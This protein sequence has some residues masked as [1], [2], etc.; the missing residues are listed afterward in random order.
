MSQSRSRSRSSSHRRSEDKD[1]KSSRHDDH[2]RKH[3]N[4][5]SKHDDD[6]EDERL[7]KQAKEFIE[8]HKKGQQD[9]NHRSSK[10]KSSR[11]S[12]SRSP[13]ERSRKRHR[14]DRHDKEEED[15]EGD[16][17]KSSSKNRD[18]RKSSSRKSHKR[19]HDD[20]DHDDGDSKSNHDK[21]KR[22][23][24]SSSRDDKDSRKESRRRAS[25]SSDSDEDRKKRSSKSRDDR[26][27]R[28]H[29]HHKKE[30]KHSSSKKD[31]KKH[32]KK[33]DRKSDD[34]KHDNKS[35]PKKATAKTQKPDKASLVP[36]GDPPGKAPSHLLDADRDYF[37][38]H[39]SLW[40]WLYREEGMAF[41]DMTSDE[42][43]DA[44]GRFV[45]QYN[46]GR[47]EAA[48]YDEKGLPPAAVEECK[49]TRHQ[50]SFQT[51][52][53]ERK[54]L[55]LLEDGVRKLTEYSDA[56][57]NNTSKKEGQSSSGAA[58]GVARK[59]APSVAPRPNPKD[60]DDN[61]GRRQPWTAEERMAHR[62]ANKR[63]KQH[64]RTAE[65]EFGGGAKDYGRERQLEKK[66]EVGARTHGAARDREDPGVT[67][68]DDALYGDGGHGAT[69]QAAL[70]RE[71]KRKAHR[72]ES[73]QARI[74]ELQ[75]KEQS[76]QQAMLDMLGLAGRPAGQKIKIAP[77][78]DGDGT[79]R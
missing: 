16:R 36:L 23:H 56:T 27:D 7:L 51:S 58:L 15:D 71:R 40:V 37:A 18:D 74:Q 35:H 3:R 43:R 34:H 64:V 70:S 50:W 57:G 13:E 42:S 32:K 67:I 66:K 49:T 39:Q 52:E 14:R 33:K 20:K 75:Q 8:Q 17:H 24:S 69:F 60:A 73:K 77:R 78:K 68:S 5:R 4:S 6:D 26:E 62:T 31:D 28:K 29:K 76:K 61:D 63:L 46:A 2:K 30:H 22:K 72:E 9:N 21:E 45:Q 1:R 38:F 55:K 53:T 25:P 54:G 41:N 47:L 59:P 79:S 12:R 11:R 44:F 65:E 48:Y 10:K 19:D